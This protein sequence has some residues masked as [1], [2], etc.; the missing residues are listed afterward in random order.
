MFWLSKSNQQEIAAKTLKKYLHGIK[1]WHLLHKQT[2]P[3]AANPRLKVLLRSSAGPNAVIPPKEKKGAIHL[4]HLMSLSEALVSVGPKEDAVLDLAL[5][6][7]WGLARIG[8]LTSPLPQGKVDPW[9]SF[10]T[11]NVMW[12]EF[13]GE[14]AIVLTLREAKTCCPSKTQEILLRPLSNM[15]CPV[16]AVKRRL[17]KSNGADPPLLGYYDPNG[18]RVHLTKDTVNKTLNDVWAKGSFGGLT[19]HSFRVGGASI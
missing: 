9:T 19:G 2:Y 3:D 14:Q 11:S 5:V 15:L 12:E 10:L 4:Q 1:A 18:E 16:E 6:A 17:I 8:K 7:F 13:E